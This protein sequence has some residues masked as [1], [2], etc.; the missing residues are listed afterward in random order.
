MSTR[1]SSHASRG[2][3][4]GWPLCVTICP[5]GLQVLAYQGLEQRHG[6][7]FVGAQDPE[8]V[9][10][11]VTLDDDEPREKPIMTI[12]CVDVDGFT[13]EMESAHVVYSH[14]QHHPKGRA[15]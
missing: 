14:E 10:R 12:F 5:T 4:P 2:H 7:T 6:T 8:G 9:L 11:V 13:R 15:A 3:V 1:N